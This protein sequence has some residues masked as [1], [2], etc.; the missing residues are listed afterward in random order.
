VE[1]DS[2]YGTYACLRCR[3]AHE[4]FETGPRGDCIAPL[5]EYIW[6][7]CIIRVQASSGRILR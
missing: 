3:L 5:L 4:E 7:I 6:G 1:Q 2:E